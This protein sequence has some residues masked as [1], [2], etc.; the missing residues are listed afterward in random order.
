MILKTKYYS[1]LLK[2]FWVMVKRGWKYQTG[3]LSKDQEYDPDAHSPENP[4][5]GIGRMSPMEQ[6]EM[7]IHWETYR[8]RPLKDKLDKLQP[9]YGFAGYRRRG[10]ER[11]Y[12]SLGIS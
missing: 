8:E 11:D 9:K 3:A 5:L 4:K 1:L 12:R 7:L 2:L 10:F 6:M